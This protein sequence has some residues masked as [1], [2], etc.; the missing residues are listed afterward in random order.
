MK[1]PLLAA[2]FVVTGSL[3]VLFLLPAEHSER[4]RP[5][6]QRYL[7]QLVSLRTAAPKDPGVTYLRVRPADFEKGD[8]APRLDWAILMNS[9]LNFSPQAAGIVPP[10]R[11]DDTDVLTEGALAK[12]IKRM[13]A[14]ALGAILSPSSPD[15]AQEKQAASF[16]SLERVTGDRSQLLAA[17][18]VSAMPDDELLINGKPGFTRI[19]LQKDLGS[20]PNG[21]RMPLVCRLGDR[22]V[23][24]FALQLVMLRQG[25]LPGDVAIHLDGSPPSIQLGDRQT[26]PIDSSGC[27][28]VHHSL[29]RA[30]PQIDFAS[31]ALAVSP[32]QEVA[33]E[34]R[35]ATQEELESLRKNAVVIGFDDSSLQEF[36]LPSSEK[37][38][39]AQLL[40][41]A[42]ASI[43]SGYHLTNWETPLHYGSL[44]A[45]ALLGLLLLALP[46][47]GSAFAGLAL[48]AL[49]LAASWYLFQQSLS[50]TPPWAALMLCLL[51]TLIGAAFPRKP[52]R[53]QWFRS[54]SGT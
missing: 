26:I 2:I 11:W 37:I 14:M 6:N 35:K 4:F 31:L 1:F 40:T 3:A 38:S 39:L 42:V 48:A 34:L 45:V 5:W 54:K 51:S 47:W 28:E 23:P 43:Q 53:K 13:P 32:F 9:L 16:L 46:R 25:L 21:L 44:G 20:G 10:L 7:D 41:M 17:R 36:P 29:A 18:Q 50:W 30:F 15:S 52:R 33:Q 8:L 19:E 27:L 24:S 12:Q 22:V 49:Y